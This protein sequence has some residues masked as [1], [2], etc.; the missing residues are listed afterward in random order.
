MA[1][2]I[3]KILRAIS[4]ENKW[5]K[6][7]ADREKPSLIISD[8]RFGLH[9]TTIPSVYI[10]HQLNIKTPARV[11]FLQPLL[12]TLH[13]EAIERFT[14]CWIPDFESPP[15]L[16]GDLSHSTRPRRNAKYIGP[17]S[18]FEKRSAPIPVNQNSD[19][20]FDLIVI[21]S[22]PE[23]QR[24]IF[25]ELILSQLPKTKLKAL[26]IAGR[27][28]EDS[29]EWVTDRVRLVSRMTSAA[30]KDAIDHSS[31]VLSR[32]GYSTVMDLAVLEKR[33][34]FVPTPGQTEQEYLGETLRT[35]PGYVVVEQHRFNLGQ[36]WQEIESKAGTPEVT[37]EFTSFIPLIERFLTAKPR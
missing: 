6:A 32:P 13:N 26:V 20:N 7:W 11:A 28:E 30:L 18:R 17:L 36:A 5:L 2:Q 35:K 8:N 34:I 19:D 12:A 3:P 4:G 23:P 24:S 1:R 10:T 15:G 21:L 22:G 27:S 9:H 16:A 33:A 14:E 31:V 25:E 29:D 37:G